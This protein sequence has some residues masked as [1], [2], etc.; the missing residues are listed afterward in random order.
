MGC[1]YYGG[2]KDGFKRGMGR[3]GRGGGDT[4]IDTV[5]GYVLL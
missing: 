2:G 4:H 5:A 1:V 3:W